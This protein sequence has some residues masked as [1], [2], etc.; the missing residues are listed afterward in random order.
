MDKTDD[1]LKMTLD[2]IYMSEM[3][4]A[5]KTLMRGIWRAVATLMVLGG[6]C[7]LSIAALMQKGG[8]SVD[9]LSFEA[10]ATF[11]I[12]AVAYV[13]AAKTLK[14]K[15]SMYAKT[16]TALTLEHIKRMQERLR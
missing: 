4:K 10:I 15:A 9:L 14:L 7:G 16:M 3:K 2:E 8:F 11:A 13:I 5:K 6:A 1:F 12:A